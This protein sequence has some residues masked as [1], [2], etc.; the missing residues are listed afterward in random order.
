[1]VGKVNLPENKPKLKNRSDFFNKVDKLAEYFSFKHID[2]IIDKRDTVQV[3]SI[4]I[5]YLVFLR[6]LPLAKD[7]SV[8]VFGMPY[9]LILTFIFLIIFVM[10]IFLFPKKS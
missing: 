2:R 3:V 6:I 10:I 9:W 8:N 7:L 5:I 1:M 4:I